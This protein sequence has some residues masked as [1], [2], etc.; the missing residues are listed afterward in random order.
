MTMRAFHLVRTADPSGVSG[1]GVVAEGVQFTSGKVALNWRS[2]VPSTELH[3][4]IDDVR[5]VHG[6]GGATR[7]A[8]LEEG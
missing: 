2:E 1:N 3:D 6:H 8:W 7:I 5:L 4:D